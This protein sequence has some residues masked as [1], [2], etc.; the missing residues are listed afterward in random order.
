MEDIE[1]KRARARRWYHENKDKVKAYQITNKDKIKIYNTLRQRKF[2]G[3]PEP[4]RDVPELCECCGM[5]SG[6]KIMHLDHCHQTNKFRGWL[7]QNC[8]LGIG[9]LG[10]SENGLIN[11]LN[12]LRR[13]YDNY[14][15]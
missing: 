13:F 15:S 9:L 2:A 5:P 3:L 14:N 8:N 11:A 4:T 10:D 12:Y 1:L 7:C 6:K